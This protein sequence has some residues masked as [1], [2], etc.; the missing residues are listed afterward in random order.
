MKLNPPFLS[1]RRIK[2]LV[3]D[4]Y[5]VYSGATIKSAHLTYACVYEIDGESG[6]WVRLNKRWKFHYYKESLT[7]A[8]SSHFG[9]Y[10]FVCLHDGR[11]I[12][13]NSLIPFAKR[14]D[15]LLKEIS[16]C[17][18]KEKNLTNLKGK[19][20]SPLP[21][22]PQKERKK[23]SFP[24]PVC[25]HNLDTSPP[26]ICPNC[27]TGIPADVKDDCLHWPEHKNVSPDSNEGI[28][29]RHIADC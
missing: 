12:S 28:D 3:L 16:E 5:A 24:C 10:P 26:L 22:A 13:P 25:R 20:T 6:E 21:I 11:N 18:T 7:N 1:I 8:L 29:G 14:F 17:S 19:S 23:K 9:D 15:C 2:V 27:K 4:A